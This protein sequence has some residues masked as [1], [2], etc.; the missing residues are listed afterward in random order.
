MPSRAGRQCVAN[1]PRRRSCDRSE[2]SSAPR[3]IP[4]V[5][6][7]PM[8][9]TDPRRSSGSSRRAGLA[10][11]PPEERALPIVPALDP[12]RYLRP[13]TPSRR[14]SR[15][16]PSRSSPVTSGT[17]RPHRSMALRTPR[18]RPGPE[19]HHPRPPTADPGAPSDGAGRCR[20]RLPRPAVLWSTPGP[21]TPP[22]G[23]DQ[24]G[25]GHPSRPPFRFPLDP[26]P[27]LPS[28]RLPAVPP[29]ERRCRAASGRRH[30]PS[31]RRPPLAS[32]AAFPQRAPRGP[33]RDGGA[34]SHGPR[35]SG[36]AW[37]PR[38]SSP[39]NRRGTDLPLPRIRR[40]R[41]YEPWGRAPRVTPRPVPGQD[42]ATVSE[43]RS[44]TRKY[45]ATV[46]H[47]MTSPPR[48]WCSGFTCADS[49]L[50]SGRDHGAREPE[51]KERLE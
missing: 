21:A 15:L 30:D 42:F 36:K 9:T 34:P 6:P 19:G 12:L 41:R 24:G 18:A 28:H 20:H 29:E 27:P 13:A 44:T 23:E 48:A 45:Y 5:P 31:P 46:S 38:F 3:E 50:A 10:P 14:P 16:R 49:G 40:D 2:E 39:A 25:A 1:T 17:L 33:L 43:Y 11:S 4:S 37:S 7:D 32:G 26:P 22:G 8:A 35:D 47:A 51:T